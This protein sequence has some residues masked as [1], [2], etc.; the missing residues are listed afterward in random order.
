MTRVRVFLGVL[1]AFWAAGY[2]LASPQTLPQLQQ[3]LTREP[4]LRATFV[5]L[6]QV[7]GLA[8]PLRSSGELLFSRQHGL[9]WH[10]TQPFELTLILDESRLR[11]QLAGQPAEEIRAADNPQLFEF[12]HLLLSL[13][14]ADQTILQQHFSLVFSPEV[15]RWR[16]TLTPRQAPLNQVFDQLA[17][18]GAQE[19]QQLQIRDRQGDETLLEFSAIQHLPRELSDVEQQRFAH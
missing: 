15:E 2:C 19:L 6:K 1:I 8:Q 4:T 14:A 16:L 9:W 12:S 3:Q 10:Q 17:L 11:Q 13:F 5:Q 7:T 18:E